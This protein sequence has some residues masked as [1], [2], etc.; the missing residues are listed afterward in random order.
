MDQHV[1]A[2]F[3]T[4]LDQAPDER[5]AIDEHLAGC[6]ACSEYYRKMSLLLTQSGDTDVR[7]A[8]D[9]HLPAQILAHAPSRDAGRRG[10][11]LRWSAAGALAILAVAIGISLG[12]MLAPQGATYSTS[13]I[14]GAYYSAVS[15]QNFSTRWESVVDSTRKE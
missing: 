10:A 14:A 12:E 15:Q 7:L 4:W 2:Y 3:L 1:T 11:A 5:R 6:R 13:D 8:A 9:P